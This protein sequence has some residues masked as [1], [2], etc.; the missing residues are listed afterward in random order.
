MAAEHKRKIYRAVDLLKF[1]I[2][3]L[4]HTFYICDCEIIGCIHGVFL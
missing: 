1:A 2:V 3:N 4:K